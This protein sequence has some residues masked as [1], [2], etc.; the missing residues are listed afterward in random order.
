MLLLLV[1]LLTAGCATRP[2]D[3]ALAPGGS[4]P[5]GA[6]Q[7]TIFVATDPAPLEEKAVGTAVERAAL[8]YME[9][10][11]SVPPD[12]QSGA[13]EWSEAGAGDPSR[14]FVV[15]GRRVLDKAAFARTIAARA[16]PKGTIGIFV[17][18]YNYTLAE[19]AFRTAQLS[20]D[21]AGVDVPILFSWPSEG[22]V[23]GYVADRDA[24]TYARDDLAEVMKIVGRTKT[25]G[26]IFLAGHSM[27]GW[28][29][30]ETLRQLR[31]EKRDALIA[32]FDVALAAP[33]I[34][35]DVFR[36]QLDVVGPLDPPLTLL[37][38]GDDRALA[39]SRRLSGNRGRV[40]AVDVGDP[41]LQ[42][43]ATRANLRIVDISSVTAG[44]GAR[45]DRFVRFAALQSRE[46][47][48]DGGPLGSI[49]RAGAYVFDAAGATVASPFVLASRILGGT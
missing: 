36:R 14:S 4:A 15:T 13:V 33:D 48:R 40:G 42:A 29:V 49:G 25:S 1:V 7:V 22:A 31:L 41:E 5:S 37:V 9:L 45:H 18:G 28:L 12:H 24:A 43:V 10:T 21:T 2:G 6:R 39:L 23:T 3:T 30:M 11:V 46:A 27:G 38:A 19:A 16:G 20:A 26:R 47:A 44:D 8:N 35:V 32:R 34:D 17:H